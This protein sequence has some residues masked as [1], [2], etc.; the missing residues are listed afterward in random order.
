MTASPEPIHR[1][2]PAT[3]QR[4]KRRRSLQLDLL[5]LA[6]KDRIRAERAAARTWAEIEQDSPHWPEWEQAGP[7]VLARFPERRLPHSNLQRWYDLRVEQ[8][9]RERQAQSAAAHAAAEQCAA[10]G[11][12]DLTAAV[13]NALGEAVFELTLAGAG[14]DARID[15]LTNLSRVLAR[16]EAT[17]ISRQRLELEMRK[18]E[19]RARQPKSAEH[20]EV[21]RGLDPQP[22]RWE[23]VKEA[24]APAGPAIPPE[25]PA[26]RDE[27]HHIPPYP[28]NRPL[29][30]APDTQGL[31][32]VAAEAVAVAAPSSPGALQLPEP[33]ASRDETQRIPPYPPTSRGTKAIVEFWSWSPR[34]GVDKVN[35]PA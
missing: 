3:G 21:N 26:W 28:A 25:S 27:T 23:K 35:A 19:A 13:K 10:R 18:A 33:P 16:M 14:L 31:A 20:S 6:L 5:P 1:T 29:A 32:P 24:E 30:I 12:T 8:V 4:R 17:E 22:G 15:A 2:H 9:M 7:E 34:S 11:F